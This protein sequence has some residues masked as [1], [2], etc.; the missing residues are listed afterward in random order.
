MGIPPVL[1][2]FNQPQQGNLLPRVYLTIWIVHH[3]SSPSS[4]AVQAEGVPRTY[5]CPC[6]LLFQKG[7]ESLVGLTSASATQAIEMRHD[8]TLRRFL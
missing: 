3:L 7:E 1:S 5:L 2:S 6:E 4:S 8:P